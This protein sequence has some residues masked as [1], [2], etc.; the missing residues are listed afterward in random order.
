[1]DAL[2]EEVADFVAAQALT[3]Q[4]TPLSPEAV[5]ERLT[6]REEETVGPEWEGEGEELAPP[7]EPGLEITFTL[8]EPAQP[9][10]YQVAFEIDPCLHGGSVGRH[11]FR[12]QGNDSVANVTFHATRG[13]VTVKL[14]G[15][16]KSRTLGPATHGT[17]RLAATPGTTWRVT[18]YPA[19]SHSC[20]T[21]RGDIAV[22]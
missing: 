4:A 5:Q 13:L 22:N 20:Y 15:Q 2:R 1:M 16:G 6:V 8:L 10:P 9:G 14:A 12:L 19:S 3:V 18:V 21:L 17:I 7:D 11:T